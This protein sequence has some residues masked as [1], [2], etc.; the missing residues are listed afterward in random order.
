MFM[1]LIG[2]RKHPEL[3]SVAPV[4]PNGIFLLSSVP[5]QCRNGRHNGHYLFYQQI[6]KPS[7]QNI[8]CVFYKG[9]CQVNGS[10][11]F[12][13]HVMATVQVYGYICVPTC[14]RQG[15]ISNTLLSC[16]LCDL[17]RHRQWLTENRAHQLARIADKTQGHCYPLLPSSKAI[18]IPHPVLSSFFPF[19]LEIQT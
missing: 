15:L 18:S 14:G 8:L 9:R 17:L 12:T 13:M 2:K 19:V 16:S 11:L 5:Q 10:L 7:I 3:T 4:T 6:C 1:N